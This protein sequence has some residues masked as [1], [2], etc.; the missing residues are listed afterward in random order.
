MCSKYVRSGNACRI[1]PLTPFVKQFSETVED[2]RL[3]MRARLASLVRYV[4]SR[5]DAE[6]VSEVNS[7]YRTCMQPELVISKTG[8]LAGV[9]ER[10]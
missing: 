6:D 7:L 2:V 1:S 9:K 10:K 5:D 3:H 8:V 4:K